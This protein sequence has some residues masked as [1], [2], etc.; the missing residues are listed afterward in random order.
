MTLALALAFALAV[1]AFA[2]QPKTITDTQH[3]VTITLNGYLRSE[4][5]NV[6][7]DA[8]TP[9]TLHVVADG[10]TVEIKA[11]DGFKYALTDEDWEAFE[12]YV[13]EHTDGSFDSIADSGFAWNSSDA[14][15]YY[16]ADEYKLGPAQTEQPPVP[17]QPNVKPTR[18][19]S[20]AL[21]DGSGQFAYT[22]KA[23]DTLS[24]L[25]HYYYGNMNVYKLIYGLNKDTIKSPNLIYVGQT[26]ILPSY[27]AATAYSAK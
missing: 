11:M 10:S 6:N 20:V 8:E 24:G 7:P 9:A 16:I 27:P 5:V 4:L 19:Q 22:I 17:A 2:A 15:Q 14:Y 25:A 3:G 13:Y 1:P 21:N 23:G 18:G 12:T 26:I